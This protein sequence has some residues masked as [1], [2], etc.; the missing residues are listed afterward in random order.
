MPRQYQQFP[1][2]DT[3]AGLDTNSPPDKIPS[4]ALSSANNVD[5]ESNGT[6]STRKG[7]ERYFGNF[8]MRVTSAVLQ[9]VPDL[10]GTY[11]DLSIGTASSVDFTKSTG[12]YPITIKGNSAN[13]IIDDAI[14][15]S[16]PD[17]F[18]SFRV[19]LRKRFDSSG[20][21]TVEGIEFGFLD[22]PEGI[23]GLAKADNETNY[24]HSQLEPEGVT[25]NLTEIQYKYEAD[26]FEGFIYFLPY[27][28][29]DTVQWQK[30][31]FSLAEGVNTLSITPSVGTRNYI[32]DVYA[33]DGD[34]YNRIKPET[35]TIDS[36]YNVHV[37]IF[38]DSIQDV[39]IYIYAAN[40]SA[41]VADVFSGELN[42]VYLTENIE[43]FNVVQIW[44]VSDGDEM[45]VEPEAIEYG[46][47][48][49]G[50]YENVVRISYY[51]P[52]GY[53]ESLR[54]AYQP[55]IYTG[56]VL[57]LGPMNTY[58]EYQSASDNKIQVWG[59]DH[60][61]IYR[62]GYEQTAYVTGIDNYRTEGDE[63]LVATLAGNV[64]HAKSY[65]DDSSVLGSNV[66]LGTGTT[67]GVSVISPRTKTV[68]IV[69]DAGVYT[70]A[71]SASIEVGDYLTVSG[72]AF[73][74][75]NG[76]F[77]VLEI[78]GLEFT[79]D[80]AKAKHEQCVATANIY[81][82]KIK[83]KAN[84]FTFLAGDVLY[85]G[86]RT[87]NI[88][89][90]GSDFIRISGIKQTSTFTNAYLFY[91]GRTSNTI[92][93]EK[94]D[95]ILRG[96]MIRVPGYTRRLCV[97]NVDSV[98]KT[99]TVDESI[100]YKAGP[101]L[102]YATVD[103]RWRVV[104]SPVTR[105]EGREEKW[106]EYHFDELGYEVST[107][108]RSTVVSES[109]YL[110]NGADETKKY[111][112]S[113]V[114][115][116]G[117]SPFQPWCFLSV[118][119]D[120]TGGALTGGNIVEFEA[121]DVSFD[122]KY[123]VVDSSFVQVG[124]RIK[125]ST[126]QQI[127]TVSSVTPLGVSQYKI[128]VEE[129]IDPS[130]KAKVIVGTDPEV[131]QL[132]GITS[133]DFS[134]PINYIVQ[135]PETG[136]ET[137]TVQAT[138]RDEDYDA[139]LISVKVAGR[140]VELDHVN[141]TANV[142]QPYSS[143]GPYIITYS[144]PART[145]VEWKDNSILSGLTQLEFDNFI[146]YDLSSY[147]GE[148]TQTRIVIERADT[149]KT[150]F[151]FIEKD[152]ITLSRILS[153]T[154]KYDDPF[155]GGSGI[156]YRN[157]LITYS[158]ELISGVSYDPK[159]GL[160]FD[161]GSS[162]L[163]CWTGTFLTDPDPI[164]IFPGDT[165]PSGIL[166]IYDGTDV[167]PEHPASRGLFDV[168]YQTSQMYKVVD[169]QDS[170]GVGPLTDAEPNLV[171]FNDLS[172]NLVP[173]DFTESST[174]LGNKAK[175]WTLNSANDAVK[176]YVWYQIAGSS[177]VDPAPTS[178]TGIAVSILE[179]DSVDSIAT[180]TASAINALSSFTASAAGS[181]VTITNAVNGATT[182]AE[183][184]Y[185]K[186]SVEVTTQGTS[187]LKEVTKV[188]MT[189][190]GQKLKGG[191]YEFVSNPHVSTSPDIWT[192]G[193]HTLSTN[194]DLSDVLVEFTTIG[195]ATAKIYNFVTK[196]WDTLKS[197]SKMD[198]SDGG[199]YYDTE[200]E[201]IAIVVAATASYYYYMQRIKIKQAASSIAYFK[202]LSG[203][204]SQIETTIRGKEYY[205][206]ST[207]EINLNAKIKTTPLRVRQKDTA[208]GYVPSNVSIA[209]V[210][211]GLPIADVVTFKVPESFDVTEVQ[212][213]FSYVGTSVRIDS[214]F[215]DSGDT[216]NNFS[217]NV[218]LLTSNAN[219]G[220][221][222]EYILTLVEADASEKT[223]LSFGIGNHVGEITGTDI[224]VTVP[225]GT[226]LKTLV[227]TFIYK[228][229]EVRLGSSSG[230]LVESSRT[231]V[232]FSSSNPQVF[233]VLDD[234]GAAVDYSVTVS[235]ANFKH[236]LATDEGFI[237]GYFTSTNNITVE[238]PHEEDATSLV[239]T[240]SAPGEDGQLKNA[241][242][243][244]YYMKYTAL[245]SNNNIICSA[246]LGADDMYAEVF[247]PSN[248]DIKALKMP[249]FNELDYS[250]VEL[251][252][253]RTAA[254]TVAPFYNVYRG[255]IDYN[256][257]G[258]YVNFKDNITE[259]SFTANLLDPISTNLL[260]GELG[261]SINRPPVGK[262]MTSADNRLIIGNI[263]SPH[264]ADVVI[265]KKDSVAE[266]S[267]SDFDG[268]SISLT[269]LEK[270]LPLEIAVNPTFTGVT[271]AADGT[272]SQPL[273]LPNQWVYLYYPSTGENKNLSLVGWF[274]TD[275]SGSIR[276]EGDGT[277][278][279]N[280]VY[281]VDKIPVY[282]GVDGNINQRNFYKLPVESQLST[283]ISLAINAVM[284]T[285]SSED[286]WLLSQ[287]GQ[288]YP[289]GAFRLQQVA[290]P[291]GK[292]SIMPT[293]TSDDFEV[294]INNLKVVS[295]EMSGTEI[296]RFP[297]RL[298]VSYRNFP[299]IFNDCY[300]QADTSSS[301]IDVNPADGQEITA[302]MPFFGTSA[303][304][305]AQLSQSLVVFK[306]NSIYLVD[307]AS[308]SVQ[309]LQT[310]GQGCTAPKS[311]ATTKNGIFFANESGIYRLGSDMRITWIGR[312]LDGVWRNEIE[313]SDM[314]QLAGH[315]YAQERRYK[316]SY[317][318]KGEADNSKVAVYSS[319]REEIGQLG[320]WTLYDNHP[321]LGW[322]NQ[323]SDSFF[324]STVGKVYKVR[325]L[326]QSS[327]YRD[328]DQGIPVSFV[329][330]ATN[331][332]MP[333]E[334]KTV[335]SVT[336][337]FQNEYGKISDVQVLTEQ[338][339]SGIFNDSGTVTIP[340][341]DTDA[342]V[343]F[344]LPVRKGTH[345][346]TK[347]EKAG[348]VDEKVQVSS[349]TYGVKTNGSDGVPQANKFRS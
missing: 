40:Y 322:C 183:D 181:V 80:N 302:A 328:D 137:Y 22:H 25:T 206:S 180:K 237:N 9:Y 49:N 194:T 63:N 286:A 246:M 195:K 224:S 316:L 107:D 36:E 261:P 317:P 213:L 253:Y 66:I 12:N 185:A 299:E 259:F 162:R 323:T 256:D 338:S 220:N 329:Y 6:I 136:V 64:I 76:T 70:L 24:F 110:S 20:L 112:G 26:Q 1:L 212:L 37:T 60:K 318:V 164:E 57:R 169:L 122:Q 38:S 225:Y 291:D 283:K 161:I 143:A 257:N 309:K 46:T 315:N 54:I 199:N 171:Y 296:R 189:L 210:I 154:V 198:L 306:T 217:P 119:S 290:N 324:S 4:G 5:V 227:P 203:G 30:E 236:G 240:F 175:Y 166:E 179:T 172:L 114:V 21:F 247:D 138:R 347:I 168:A 158:K 81:T 17:Y 314:S 331:F 35:V 334:R 29:S 250:R 173:V 336:I 276:V 255:L 197:G 282:L 289:L 339:L 266:L 325:N 285:V 342:T 44:A 133:N 18:S 222:R 130:L 156:Y 293:F 145:S 152:G 8:P 312:A 221:S 218:E 79:T 45:L 139:S 333:D 294:F 277:T 226:N 124:D 97:K 73:K 160:N 274:K 62:P 51:L 111:D 150:Q 65:E 204:T 61:D 278:L 186:V 89:G 254:N 118:D 126:S 134:A 321:A 98:N 201:S 348:V 330:G 281:I 147:S 96:D 92:P 305:S 214:T 69:D 268:M 141:K 248:I 77:K 341:G 109:M 82:G 100:F 200:T 125:V 90:S 271:V 208:V 151:D 167:N 193:N 117:L 2:Q 178:K 260:G 205:A 105:G 83:I 275:S 287:G 10:D 242:V 99:V 349:I 120:G 270:S 121:I 313:K 345:V 332:E 340:E 231:V 244:R 245:D 219:S 252:I 300:P 55:A 93:L 7:Y 187:A 280:A 298:A 123:F 229:K 101:G 233:S 209:S 132:S 58:E 104:E 102:Q 53:A 74:S 71:D 91:I 320:S 3:G 307:I 241:N 135:I 75:N 170:Y 343:R 19:P 149:K 211:D 174:E 196:T 184:V 39:N 190:D 140:Q 239:A 68:T 182:D 188:T 163:L 23:F 87:Y 153:P 232:D 262:V 310:Q 52:E 192:I 319:D 48:E 131:E 28:A 129:D 142:Y 50:E 144:A 303:F 243:Y 335:D 258:G 33:I 215:Q 56:N 295:G 115:N 43:T 41:E 327:D 11:L 108:V 265:R 279:V 202:T 67:D 34:N 216:V 113:S 32:V 263:T 249:A 59:L 311:V 106:R 78:N 159:K 15:A 230:D 72:C 47:F 308:N 292:I 301:I 269:S 103:G 177:Q 84:H 235:I 326:G 116:A 284:A 288:S 94:V 264:L 27:N 16:G 128:Y 223:F 273:I 267:Y 88:V 148:K 234:S 344:S 207:P 346:R 155:T 304:G 146:N 238:I 337:Q 13:T 86:G 251:E 191:T 31:T 297:S 228:G 165:I 272:L 176:Y 127:L 42:Y 157:D 85:Y 95:Y 14:N